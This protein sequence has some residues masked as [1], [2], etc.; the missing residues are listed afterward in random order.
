MHSFTREIVL[1]YIPAYSYEFS[2]L[3]PC[4]LKYF[5]AFLPHLESPSS[6]FA[7]LQLL[8]ILFELLQLIS[9]MSQESLAYHP[10]QGIWIP[11]EEESTGS[12]GPSGYENEF[13]SFLDNRSGP[14]GEY[15]YLLNLI[16][17]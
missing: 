6:W 1:I 8:Y 7:T 13:R 16:D 15:P 2:I 9:T 17:L 5:G 11:V 4:I 10:S 14:P 3:L 12:G